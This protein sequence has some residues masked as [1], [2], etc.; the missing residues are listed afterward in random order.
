M[1][2]IFCHLVFKNIMQCFI[3]LNCHDLFFLLPFF[4]EKFLQEGH[5]EI[6]VCRRAD[7]S[8]ASAVTQATGRLARTTCTECMV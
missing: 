3:F 1:F 5:K 7:R 8:P 4:H 2:Q 6:D